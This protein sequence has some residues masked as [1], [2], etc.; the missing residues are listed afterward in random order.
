MAA[1]HFKD[2]GNLDVP[3]AGARVASPSSGAEGIESEHVGA[4]PYSRA[5]YTAGVGKP[6]YRKKRRPPI[7]AVLVVLAVFVGVGLLLWLNP[8]LYRVTVNGVSRSFTYGATVQTAVDEGYAT[9]TAGNLIAVDDSV[10]TPG[11]GDPFEATINGQK[12][13]DP[14]TA[15]SRDSTLEITD[16]DDIPETYTET[17]EAVPHGVSTSTD[18]NSAAAYYNGSIHVYLDGEDGEQVVRLG[19]VSGKTVSEVTKQ[20][21]D[22]GY[23]VYTTDVGDDKV[24]A[25]T[26]DDGPWPTT[27][28]QILDVLE[29]YE[30]KATFFEIGNQIPDNADVVKRIHED[31]YQIACHTYDHASGSGRGVDLTLMSADEQIAEVD[32]GF[33]SI[34]DMLG[35]SVSRVM[36]APGGNY[37]GPLIDRLRGHIT[38]EI[39]WDV[40]TEDWRRP[41]V[42]KIV[43]AIMTVKPG[44]VILMHDGGGDR[45]QTLEAL[46]IA[47][48][49]LKDEGYTFVTVDE[50]LAY[51]MP[52]SK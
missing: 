51:G 45:T 37:Y 34:E 33:K 26:F 1:K 12:V 16:G 14:T 22:E 21:V 7:A 40:D 4:D 15:L 24:I 10:A 20:P 50:L 3:E 35:T 31:G 6:V 42:D 23:H 13:D 44:Q 52:A 11:G 8:P 49:Q 28:T 19:D 32:N 25:L 41:G 43:E 30:A 9:P 27:T 46:K 5:A 38:A 2:S 47:L 29:Q 36:R 39:G 18:M 48:P 17:T